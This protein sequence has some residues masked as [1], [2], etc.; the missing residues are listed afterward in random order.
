MQKINVTLV[1]EIR[2][3][4]VTHAKQFRNLITIVTC[5][6]QVALTWITSRYTDNYKI[7]HTIPDHT[8]IFSFI[9][10]SYFY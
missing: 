10:P 8:Y 9:A 6:Q 7:Y 5:R 4:K 1:C 3:G 2:N